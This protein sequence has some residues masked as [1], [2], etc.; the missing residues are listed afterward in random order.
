MWIDF[1]KRNYRLIIAIQ[2]LDIK[3]YKLVASNIVK[4]L[5]IFIKL[6]GIT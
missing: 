5:L 2:N 1:L 6:I 4:S 3:C